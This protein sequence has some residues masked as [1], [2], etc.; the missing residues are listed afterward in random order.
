MI[1]R[2][3]L[4]LLVSLGL[5]CLAA[6]GVAQSRLP[7]QIESATIRPGWER[8]DGTRIAALHVRLAPG[9]KTYWRIPGQAGIAPRMDWSRS[10]NL[11]EIT[12]H[13]PRPMVFDQGGYRSIG[14]ERDLVLPLELTPARPGRP[15]ALQ[16]HIEIGVCEDICIPVDLSLSAALRGPGEADDLIS[17]ALA[18]GTEGQSPVTRATCALVPTDH[19]AD[20][21]VHLTVPR[22][23]RSEFVVVEWP[24]QQAW[25]ADSAT[26]RE[27]DTL[28]TR[29]RIRGGGGRG[30]VLDRSALAFTLLSDSRMAWHQGCSGG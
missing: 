29:A 21:A 19:G 23:G 8:A 4:A 3:P 1:N 5:A 9:W 15:I 14:Y 2:L 22:L 30:L 10:Q 6:P 20:L 7:Q 12:L 17:A 16:G 26:H 13:W 18:R 25:V 27:G 11:A 28:V 24:D